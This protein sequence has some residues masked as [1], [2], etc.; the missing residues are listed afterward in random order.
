MKALL[1]SDTTRNRKENLKLKI[2]LF[3]AALCSLLLLQAE[4]IENLN[5]SYKYH[6]QGIAADETGVYWS[7]TDILVKTDYKGKVLKEASLPNLHGG[8]MCVA[9]GDIFVSILIRPPKLIAANNNSPAAVYQYSKDLKLKKIHTLPLKRGIDGITFYKNRFYVAPA[10]PKTRRKSV[11]I[12]IFDRNFKFLKELTVTTPTLKAFGAQNLTVVNGYIVA[13]FYDNGKTAPLLDPETLQLKG[14]IDLR[15]SVGLTQVPA[16][17]AGNA[18][19][20][21]VGRLK[22]KNGNWKCAAREVIVTSDNKVIH[23]R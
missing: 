11:P 17:I 10:M 23:K 12:A 20:Y 19:T 15:H 9:G 2:F 18:H 13:G 7:F 6:L 5:T 4:G 21:L 3:L 1:L 14:E 22:G 8:D 16:G